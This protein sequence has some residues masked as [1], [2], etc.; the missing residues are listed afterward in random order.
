MTDTIVALSSGAPPSAIGV[1]RLS[2]PQAF[3]V[4]TALAGALPPPRHAAVRR[5]RHD[6]TLLDQAL[7]LSFPAPDTATGEDLVEFHAHG[8]VAT[9]DA[10]IA[11]ILSFPGVRIAD[12]GEFT[13]RGLTNGRIDLTQ[14]EALGAL[15]AAQS[16][17]QRRAAMLTADGVLRRSIE[18]IE[19][20]LLSLSAKV[21]LTLDFAD[22][23]DADQDENAALAVR[24]GIDALAMEVRGWLAKPTVDALHRGFR[25]VLAG[26]PNAGKSTL[27]NRLV[28]RDVAIVSD[29]AG[30]TRDRIDAPVVHGG[31]AFLLTDTAGL[32]DRTD[33]AIEAIGIDLAKVAMDQADLVLWLGDT[34]PPRADMLWLYPRMDLRAGT[35]SPNR[36]P[37]SAATGEG[38]DALWQAIHA[39]ISGR[40]PPEDG[41]A[42]NRRQRNCMERVDN[43]LKAAATTVD[44]LLIAHE[45]HAARAHLHQLTGQADTESMLDAL[46]SGFCIGK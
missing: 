10:V 21:E 22:E 43:A 38:I 31:I 28:G 17:S 40:L 9:I 36:L 13:R 42:L 16:E 35:M 24:Q 5:L 25:I 14:A 39:A 44:P 37:V 15:L 2:G 41:R 33:D 23:E 6:G 46:F 45:L 4:A 3:A 34:P 27:L 30:T 32:A 8:G 19:A 11:A 12:P 26:P 29:I 20:R 1:I 18:A 7:V